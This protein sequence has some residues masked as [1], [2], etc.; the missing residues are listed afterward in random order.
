MDKMMHATTQDMKRRNAIIDDWFEENF[1]AH[2]N[3]AAL[4]PLFAI[5]DELK[6]QLS[7]RPQALTLSSNPKEIRL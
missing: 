3:G 2:A 4:A 7:T 6:E 1:A 5:R